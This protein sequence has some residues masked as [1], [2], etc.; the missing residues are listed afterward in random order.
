[1]LDPTIKL[2]DVV[3]ITEL[4]QPVRSDLGEGDVRQPQIGDVAWVIEIYKKS[5]GIRAGMQQQER[6]HRMDASI[7]DGQNQARKSEAS[8]LPENLVSAIDDTVL[9]RFVR[10]DD[11][12]CKRKPYDP[13]SS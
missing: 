6:K 9:I 2:H 3:R 10:Q 8:V 13:A 4:L 12:A 11:A 1:M 5:T 7:L